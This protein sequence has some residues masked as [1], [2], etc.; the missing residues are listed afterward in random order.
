MENKMKIGENKI[1]LKESMTGKR[2]TSNILS[3]VR[4][5]QETLEF[6]NL[7]FLFK[8]AWYNTTDKY[9]FVFIKHSFIYSSL[10]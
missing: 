7:T 3:K 8:Y 4:L 6:V 2:G 1:K 5:R 10:F 9:Y